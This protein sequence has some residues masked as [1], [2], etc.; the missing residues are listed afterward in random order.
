MFR[1]FT[2]TGD[3]PTPKVV[4]INGAAAAAVAPV[5]NFAASG[6]TTEQFVTDEERNLVKKLE[7]KAKLHDAVLDRMN[8]NVIDKIDP[9]DLRREM[10][11]LV[12]QVITSEG[13]PLSAA[14]FKAIVEELLHELLG[15]WPL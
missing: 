11:T 1:N 7:L 8:L 10:T 6:G 12:G 4:P 14:E 3:A 2:R 15:L 13:S 5:A 9:E